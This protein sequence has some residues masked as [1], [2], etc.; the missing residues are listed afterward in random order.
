MWTIDA[1]QHIHVEPTVSEREVL[2]RATAVAQLSAQG[3][4]VFL[5]ILGVPAWGC[6]CGQPEHWKTFQVILYAPS[7]SSSKK[8]SS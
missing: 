8:A 4:A 3:D 1:T 7:T 6:G 5:D 2:E